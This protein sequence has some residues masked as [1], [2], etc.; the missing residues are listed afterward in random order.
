M[1]DR[2]PMVS[3]LP[4]RPPGPDPPVGHGPFDVSSDS[5]NSTAQAAGAPDSRGF[6]A[7]DPKDPRKIDSRRV[8]DSG[9]SAMKN[10]RFWTG[11]VMLMCPALGI[12]I[13]SHG[14]QYG[15]GPSVQGRVMYRG[16]PLTKGMIFFVAKDRGRSGDIVA[17]IDREGHFSSRP[18]WWKERADRAVYSIHVFPDP[19]LR[20]DQAGPPDGTTQEGRSPASHVEQDDH[21]AAGP[22]VVLAS[23][24]ASGPM[25]PEPGGSP[26][27]P[28]R[29]FETLTPAIVVALDAEP[30]HVDVNLKD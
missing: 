22:N 29:F 11:M 17:S 28:R 18:P 4:G 21:P 6:Y 24:S 30:V 8:L 20:E 14:V 10:A 7:G 27:P 5:L 12:G 23:T 1:G 25:A 3:H 16:R 15:G 19:R 9:H 2:D 26:F 13:A